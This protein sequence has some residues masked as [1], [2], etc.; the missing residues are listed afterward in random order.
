MLTAGR[1]SAGSAIH[2]QANRVITSKATLVAAMSAAG[3]GR[4][5]TMVAATASETPAKAS[6]ISV[7]ATRNDLVMWGRYHTDLR[8]QP[9]SQ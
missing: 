2:R 1:Q 6:I 8:G 4:S 3:A 5:T 9:V 7:I